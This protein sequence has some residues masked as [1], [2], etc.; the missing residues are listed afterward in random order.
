MYSF[1]YLTN[2]YL[3]TSYA[4]LLGTVIA[5]SS[6]ALSKRNKRPCPLGPDTL[7]EKEAINIIRNKLHGIIRRC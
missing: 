5:N 7:L 6:T 3:S 1:F 4:Y 2:I